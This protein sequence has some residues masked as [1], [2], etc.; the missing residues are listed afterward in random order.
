MKFAA[1]ENAKLFIEKVKNWNQENKSKV[2][3]LFRSSMLLY[4][5]S[6]EL[7]IKARGLYAEKENIKNDSIKN[8]YDFLKIW[9]GK[10]DGH[11]YFKIIE[12]YNIKINPEEKEL[13]EN[14]LS[15]TSWAGRFPYPKREDEVLNMEINGRKHGKI[16]EKYQSKVNNFIDQQ[17][18]FMKL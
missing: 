8:F 14:F 1:D 7:I 2:R 5:V 12:H 13:L 17:I 10:S 6:I 3:G 15:Y 16:S 11:N 4:A 9:K 18:E